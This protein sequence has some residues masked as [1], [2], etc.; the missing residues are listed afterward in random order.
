MTLFKLETQL[1]SV[2]V[3]INTDN[4]ETIK[5]ILRNKNNHYYVDRL[6][7]ILEENGLIV[8][9]VIP[10]TINWWEIYQ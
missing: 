4:K 6:I 10:I 9:K 1:D 8:K 7:K 2:L 5:E 3:E